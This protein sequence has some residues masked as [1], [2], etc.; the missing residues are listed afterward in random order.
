[1]KLAI[2]VPALD[3]AGPLA[4]TLAVLADFRARGAVVIVVDGG[5]TDGTLGVAQAGADAVWVAPRGRASQMNSGASHALAR[6]A[7]VL[8][9]LH[10]DTQLPANAEVLIARALAAGSV[11][12]RFDVRIAG[13][14]PLLPMVAAFM[15]WR[16]RRSGM[17]SGAQAVFVR[18]RVFHSLGGF[19]VQPLMEDIELSTRLRELSRPACLTACVTTAGRRWDNKGFWRTVLLMWRLRAAY[20]LGEQPTALARRYGYAPRAPAAVAIMA[21]APV[22]GLAKTRLAP[23]LGEA[24]AA[25]AQRGFILRTL[26]T[27]HRAGLGAVSLHCTPSAHRLFHL[28]SARWGVPCVGQV[29]GDLGCRMASVMA[30][31]FAQPGAEPLLIVGT[32]CPVLTSP[33]LQRCAD[34]LVDHDTVLIPAEDGGYVLI[35]MRKPMPRVFE[36]VDWSTPRVMGQTRVRLHELGMTCCELPALWDVDDPVDWARWQALLAD[37]GR[38]GGGGIPAGHEEGLPPVV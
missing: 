28:L 21:K 10:A 29:D 15:N 34:A 6:A 17:A 25:R 38:G 19:P 3:E 7:D 30:G 9:F 36:A 24:G 1:M 20:A 13:R 26:G 22:A 18:R 35:G 2:V 14:S 32:D 11:W 23:V 8:L 31:H 5:S 16:S 12:G 27:A 33:M 37:G 4:H